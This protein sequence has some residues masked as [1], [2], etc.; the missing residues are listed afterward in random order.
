MTT[1]HNA[2]TTRNG[3]YQSLPNEEPSPISPHQ[4]TPAG[5]YDFEN[6]DYDYTRPPPGSPPG[7]SSRALPNE[8]GNSNGLVPSF[9]TVNTDAVRTRGG[10][11]RRTAQAVLPSHYVQRLGLAPE[12]PA[13]AVGGGTT[14]DG[15]FAN[16][17]AKPSRPLQIR[18]G[19]SFFRPC[20]SSSYHCGKT[21]QQTDMYHL[22]SQVM[23]LFWF[24]KRLRRT[25]LHHTHLHKQM[26]HHR[27]GK[28]P[29]TLPPR[30]TAQA[31]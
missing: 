26:P 25:P 13:H 12:V 3:A 14:N 27:I 16:V 10:W 23:K 19:M 22:S 7:P 8:W 30:R 21:I 1:S 11:F 29:S 24:L 28:R 31:K 20:I 9:S 18:E 17:T 2:R 5:T 6:V 4:T 15:V